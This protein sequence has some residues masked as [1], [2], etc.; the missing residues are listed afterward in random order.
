[1]RTK[2]TLLLLLLNVVLFFFIFGFERQWHTEALAAE[3]RT[4]VLGPNAANIHTL[5]ISGNALENEV[6]LEREGD[7]WS[8]T[9]PY[10]WPANP[11]AVSRIVNELQFLEHDTSFSVA[12]LGTTGLSLADYGLD[13]PTLSVTFESGTAPNSTTTTLAIGNR[14]EIGQRL[15]VLAP[16]GSKVHV[17]PDSLANSL[18]LDLAQLRANSCFTIPV[19]EVRSLNLQNDGPANVRVR[20][21][22][23]GNRWTFESPVVT[24]ASKIATEVVLNDITALR[25]NDFLGAPS[26]Q[27]ELLAL[28]GVNTPTLRITLEGNNRRETLLL[29]NEVAA[30]PP[31][32]SA[33]DADPPPTPNRAFYG[34]MEERDAIFTVVLPERL[35]SDLRNAQ[36]ELRDRV[37]LD[38]NGRII[39]AITLTDENGDEVVLQK[40][41][42]VAS[43]TLESIGAW[44]VVRRASDGTLRPQ[45]AD[46]AV[47][48]NEL[49]QTLRELRATSFE[50]DVPTDAELEA[51]GLTRPTRTITLSFAPGLAGTAAPAT[52]T[53]LIGTDQTGQRAFTRTN[54]ETFVYG[55]DPIILERTPVDPLH[56]Q[57]R[58]VQEL[59]AGARITGIS[60][61][62]LEASAPLYA[63]A[64]EGDATWSDVLAGLPPAR[65]NA[66]ETLRDELAKLRAQR[67]VQDTFPDAV[68]VNGQIRPWRYRIDVALLV[69]GDEGE[70]IQTRSFFLAERD[71]GDRQL[72]GSPDYEVVFEARPELINAVWN[73][74]YA[75]RDPGPIELTDPPADGEP[76]L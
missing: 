43:A 46:A 28:A 70:Q 34:Q 33:G 9:A 47:V 68:W 75:E 61:Y 37:V 2:I 55:V 74:T 16:D 42:T 59:P 13:D 20:L 15:Y 25:T 36:S 17:V 27:P 72:V 66:L 8:I 7:A 52:T 41:E 31:A 45:S 48:T 12:N 51:W 29:G 76:E 71:G 67:V 19:F 30:N 18:S 4:R 63:G 26:R 14:T 65:R 73:L 10:E 24:R 64:L 39:D 57:N 5:V 40:L 1:M 11:H 56:Y 44:Q 35:A 60:L 58:L 49:I 50:R 54:R 22:R 38:L 23:D 32:P 62:D 6:R 3:A 53:L 69:S 21:R